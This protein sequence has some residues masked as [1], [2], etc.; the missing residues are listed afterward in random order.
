MC[1]VFDIFYVVLYDYAEQRDDLEAEA[2]AIAESL[3]SPGPNGARNLYISTCAWG[4]YYISI[5]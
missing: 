1:D 4:D 5:I 3:N 2:E